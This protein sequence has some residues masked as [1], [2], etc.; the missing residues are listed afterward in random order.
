MTIE[1]LRKPIH[2][3]VRALDL[4]AICVWRDGR[5]GVS[6]DPSG[7]DAAYWCHARDAGKAL[8]AAAGDANVLV[9]AARFVGVGLTE[10][11]V[12]LERIG[13]ALSRIDAA[14]KLAHQRGDL[15]FFNE[16]YREHRMAARRCGHGFMPYSVARLRLRKALARVAASGGQLTRTLMAQVFD[17]VGDESTGAPDHPG[18]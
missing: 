10:H 7:A 11:S 16:L 17:G 1:K 4:V 5:I 2:D 8:R 15:A 18:R 3:Y 14:L 9:T 12:V 13:G 6:R